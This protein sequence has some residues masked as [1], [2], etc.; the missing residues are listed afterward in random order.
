[1]TPSIR[2]VLITCLILGSMMSSGCGIS[3]QP[4]LEAGEW[5]LR[6]WPVSSMDPSSFEITASFADGKISGRAA[7]NSYSGPC[8]A[9]L[10]GSF[11]VGALARTEMAGPE[12]AMRAEATYFKL[13]E[14]ARRYRIH[15]ARLILYDAQDNELLIFELQDD[16]SEN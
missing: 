7:V 8:K 3:G 11:S 14:Q 4:R 1:M 13:L 6:G 12:P 15:K 5:T 10:S 16:Q 9:G 2:A